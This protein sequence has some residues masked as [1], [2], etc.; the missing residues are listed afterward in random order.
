MEIFIHIAKIKEEKRKRKIEAVIPFEQVV[1]ININK[2]NKAPK[3]LPL[4]HG[5]NKIKYADRQQDHRSAD[6]YFVGCED[7]KYK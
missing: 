4:I 2:P 3:Y 5:I 6:A 7:R 1:I